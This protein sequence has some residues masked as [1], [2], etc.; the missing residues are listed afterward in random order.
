M[1]NQ[2]YDLAIYINPHGENRRQ[3]M[4]SLANVGVKWLGAD[5][6]GWDLE[7]QR[8][9]IERFRGDLD[10]FGFSLCSMHACCSILAVGDAAP[11]ADLIARQQEELKRFSIL[12]GKTAVYH[13]CWLTEVNFRRLDEEIERVGWEC[14]VDNYAKALKNLA[15]EA[16]KYGIEI[17]LENIM[18]CA[19]S[20]TFAGFSDILQAVDESNVGYL[21]DSGHAHLAGSNVADEIRY[22]GKR[23]MDTHF[24]D[25]FGRS[26]GALSDDRHLPPG[27]GTINWPE[28][29]KALNEVDFPGPVVFEGVLGPG[30]NLEK[31][32][33][34]G[35]LNYDDLARITIDNWRAFERMT[36]EKSP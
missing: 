2:T 13:S 6:I 34:K 32:P 7:Q 4:E 11:P 12:G 24:H 33:F 5:G 8:Q 28:V 36:L 25:N 22:A 1:K 35:T 15:R 21:L 14:F 10:D 31:G 19:R 30:D 27:L 23:L 3:I 20:E 18:Y 17:V 9:D 26:T 16:S 29:V